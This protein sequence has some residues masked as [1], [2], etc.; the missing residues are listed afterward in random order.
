MLIWFKYIVSI[1]EF[2]IRIDKK[3]KIKILC[4]K[5]INDFE[6]FSSK[7]VN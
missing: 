5:G 2:I 4:L 6:M 1:S 7:V 3:S